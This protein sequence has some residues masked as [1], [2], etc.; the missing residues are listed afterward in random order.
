[1]RRQVISLF[2]TLLILISVGGAVSIGGAASHVT[3]T[4]L[5]GVEVTKVAR[6][7]GNFLEWDIAN[8]GSSE[9]WVAP[10]ADIYMPSPTAPY[11]SK[12]N[13]MGSRG[14]SL[15][16][17]QYTIVGIIT[18]HGFPHSYGGFGWMNVPAG[19]AVKFYSH[20]VVPLYARWVGYNVQ[21]YSDGFH[22][23]YDGKKYVDISTDYS[24]PRVPTALGTNFLWGVTLDPGG[25][26]LTTHGGVGYAGVFDILIF[27][28]TIPS[29][30]PSDQYKQLCGYS[31]NFLIDGS[32]AGGNRSVIPIDPSTGQCQWVASGGSPSVAL[33]LSNQD[34]A[35]LSLGMH[36]LTVDFPGDTTYA[37]SSCKLIFQ[38]VDTPLSATQ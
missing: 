7:G 4:Q 19:G 20:G 33:V 32:P 38:I 26:V 11:F 1:M 30:A 25:N 35:K 8:L 24:D 22:Q 10:S 3:P 5:A 36:V 29:N 12:I 2:L 14:Q 31:T 6:V 13:I 23:L 34:I 9:V 28:P 18:D 15:G 37:P 17:E 27:A 21:V 16:G